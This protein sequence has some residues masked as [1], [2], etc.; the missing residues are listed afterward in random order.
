MRISDVTHAHAIAM[1]D[2]SW[3]ER[4]WPGSGYE[5]WDRAL[6]GLVERGYT[7]VRIDA[8]PHLL[9]QELAAGTSRDWDLLPVWDQHDWGAPGPVRIASVQRSLVD[10]LGR[11]RD[12]ELQV[13][14]S[15]WYRQDVLDSRMRLTNPVV[16]AEQWTAVL[17]L[18]VAEGLSDTILFV[19]LTN[20]IP[21]PSYTPFLYANWGATGIESRTSARMR[22]W[23]TTGIGMIRERH[24]DFDYC[25]SFAGE[26]LDPAGQDISGFDLL[27]LH[28]WMC[29]PEFNDFYE[30]IGYDLA[31]S[32]FGPDGYPAMQG[33]EAE[34]RRDPQ[35]WLGYLDRAI[36]AA[37][38]WSRAADLPVVTTECWGPVNYRDWPMLDWGWVKEVCAHGVERAI[39]TGRWAAVATSNFCGP[40]FRGMWRDIDWHQRLTSAITST[41]VNGKAADR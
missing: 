40:Q 37:A 26:F 21:M 14:L 20:E 35:H 10:F 28:I 8:Y 27:E 36:D 1:W 7:A 33:A 6:D 32:R 29:S 11:C 12:R 38:E 9:A 19:D 17:D 4:R 39:S 3:L 25:Y 24:P 30:R 22:E 2:F 41:E 13:G 18:I 31:A 16:Q 34:Y 15:T 5:D 23:I